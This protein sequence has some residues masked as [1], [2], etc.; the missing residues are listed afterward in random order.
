MLGE[1]WIYSNVLTSKKHHRAFTT[2]VSLT[3]SS[4]GQGK[5]QNGIEG[6]VLLQSEELRSVSEAVLMNFQN[7]HLPPSDEIC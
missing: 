3:F 1:K 6:S 4:K 7:F 2:N 5:G